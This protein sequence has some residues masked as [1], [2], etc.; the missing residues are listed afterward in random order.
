MKANIFYVVLDL[1]LSIVSMISA[2]YLGKY[3]NDK[4]VQLI[5]R[6]ILFFNFL[7]FLIL[8]IPNLNESSKIPM[9]FAPVFLGIGFI[10]SFGQNIFTKVIFKIAQQDTKDDKQSMQEKEIENINNE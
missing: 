3:R 8:I 6:P 10:M 9:T 4:F 2:V 1:I 7:F 5:I